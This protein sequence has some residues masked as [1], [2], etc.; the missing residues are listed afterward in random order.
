[1]KKYLLLVAIFFLITHINAQQNFKVEPQKPVAG[2]VIRFEWLTRNTL[3]QGKQDIEGTAYLLEGKLPL[4]LPITL[5]KD[6]GVVTGSVKTN[7][8]TKAVFFSFS[9]DDVFE[10]NNDA[11]YYTVL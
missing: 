4:A 5:K 9:K 10:N 6:G 1:M 3:L 2:S 7:D 8:S 11:G